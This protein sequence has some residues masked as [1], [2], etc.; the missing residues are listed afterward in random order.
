MDITLRP[1]GEQVV[2][3]VGASSGVGRVTARLAA[4][5]GARV[6]VAARN[7]RDLASLV[8]EIRA[9]GGRAAYQVADVADEAQVERIAECARRE[10]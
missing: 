4:E 9:G 1:I 7:E 10:F 5:R 6:V 2:V 3:V 8:D